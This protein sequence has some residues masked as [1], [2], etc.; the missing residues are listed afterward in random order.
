MLMIFRRNWLHYTNDLPP[1]E[2]PA[3]KHEARP[4]EKQE[5][6]PNVTFTRAAYKPYS[7]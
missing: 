7:T 5:H 3:L 6:I 2:E 1:T 4:W